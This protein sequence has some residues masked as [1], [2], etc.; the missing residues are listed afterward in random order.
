LSKIVV[1]GLQ[2]YWRWTR[3]ATFT[4]AACL[5]DEKKRVV[6]LV[7]SSSA[8][9]WL[10]PRTPVCQGEALEQALRRFFKHAH[11]IDLNPGLNPFWIYDEAS[12]GSGGWVALFVIEASKIA[13]TSGAPGLTFFALA[14]LPPGLDPRDA[15]RICQAAEGRTP[16]E[17]C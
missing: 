15:A 8:D 6:G 5:I 11:G 9:G 2:S 10:L 4:A 1:R 12:A 7:R 13:P 3:G 17:V 14:D 16:F